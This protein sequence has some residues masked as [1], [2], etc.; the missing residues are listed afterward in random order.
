M[1]TFKNRFNNFFSRLGAKLL[2]NKRPS[3]G[4]SSDIIV[5]CSMLWLCGCLADV[6]R[7]NNN[8]QKCKYLVSQ[9][10]G[11][12]ELQFFSD[13][14]SLSFDSKLYTI[15]FMLDAFSLE[16]LCSFNVCPKTDGMVA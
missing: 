13:Q 8:Q 6:G 12:W 11:L 9:L 14:T 2:C 1:L 3:E 7:E 10:R 4:P 5:F 16:C 15:E